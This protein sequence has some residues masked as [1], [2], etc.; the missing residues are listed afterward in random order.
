MKTPI[1]DLFSQATDQA[2]QK[3]P[4]QEAIIIEKQCNRL[5]RNIRLKKKAARVHET[6]PAMFGFSSA[7]ELLAK[8]G[9]FLEG[10]VVPHIPVK[11]DPDDLSE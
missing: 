4:E 6:I 10:K 2:F 9:I 1:D 8:L 3:L 5:I 7:L 11:V